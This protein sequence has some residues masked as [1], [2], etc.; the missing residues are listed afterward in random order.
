MSHV[1]GTRPPFEDN[2]VILLCLRELGLRFEV[3]GLGWAS[4][5]LVIVKV[6]SGL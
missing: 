6:T 5:G 4:N 3:R 2:N 1:V